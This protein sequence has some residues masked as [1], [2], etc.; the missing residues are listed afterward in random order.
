VGGG[1]GGSG[2]CPEAAP[3]CTS[4]HFGALV[5]AAK[6]WRPAGASA[7]AGWGFRGSWLTALRSGPPEGQEARPTLIGAANRGGRL[8]QGVGAAFDSNEI[9]GPVH[10]Q[11]AA[12]WPPGPYQLP[13]TVTCWVDGGKN[14]RKAKRPGFRTAFP[15]AGGSG[16]LPGPS[17]ATPPRGWSALA[18][19]N[20][21]APHGFFFGGGR[22]GLNGLMG[23]PGP[24][25][26]A[27]RPAPSAGGLGGGP[28]Q[29]R[30]A[31]GTPAQ[32]ANPPCKLPFC[33]GG[34]DPAPSGGL[35]SG[36]L[37][38]ADR[39]KGLGGFLE[40][41]GNGHIYRGWARRG[42]PAGGPRG[43]GWPERTLCLPG[44]SRATPRPRI[45]LGRAQALGATGAIASP[46]GWEARPNLGFSRA[47]GKQR[48]GL[49]TV[50]F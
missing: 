35:G 33:A 46:A 49:P 21:F 48:W 42:E 15:R 34:R 32:G 13:R 39:G 7:A 14:F 28:A 50:C 25:G 29:R 1:P 27:L 31:S 19:E 8:T 43:P 20:F 5:G 18:P 26:G 12:S 45:W 4:P 3:A 36:G 24:L 2:N 44:E 30:P 40:L 37:P 38:R 23:S 6:I 9:P 11:W 17:G 41:L 22:K 16:H 10:L 47:K